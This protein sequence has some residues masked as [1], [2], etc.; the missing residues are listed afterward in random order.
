M[1]KNSPTLAVSVPINF[2]MKFGFV[3]VNGPRKTYFVD[4]LC[5]SLWINRVLFYTF[6]YGHVSDAEECDERSHRTVFVCV[7]FLFCTSGGT[8]TDS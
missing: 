5:K 7:F 2:S 3:P 6:I 1:L 8:S 4:T